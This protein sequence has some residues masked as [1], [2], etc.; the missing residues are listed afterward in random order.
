M[1]DLI[2]ILA[3]LL[4][5]LVL[6]SA[7]IW[8]EVRQRDSLRIWL[9]RVWILY[10]IVQIGLGA[11]IRAQERAVY[12]IAFTLI[13]LRLDEGREEQVQRAIEVYRDAYRESYG[14]DAVAEMISILQQEHAE[15]SVSDAPN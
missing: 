2:V 6:L 7:W 10:L 8:A 12:A 5:P 14:S 4:V 9:G 11:L 3:H 13:H 1:R 15:D